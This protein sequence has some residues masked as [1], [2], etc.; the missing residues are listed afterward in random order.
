MVYTFPKRGRDLRL[1]NRW[2]MASLKE[3]LRLTEEGPPGGRNRV[4]ARSAR[5]MRD[6]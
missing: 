3:H 6:G 4:C 1:T 2:W 5:H